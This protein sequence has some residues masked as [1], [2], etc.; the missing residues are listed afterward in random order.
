MPP[1]RRRTSLVWKIEALL[2]LLGCSLVLIAVIDCLR[3]GT[4]LLTAWHR[5]WGFAGAVVVVVALIGAVVLASRWL[6]RRNGQDLVRK[7]RK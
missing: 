1:E 5:A 7:L 3:S 4:S 2:F 6:D